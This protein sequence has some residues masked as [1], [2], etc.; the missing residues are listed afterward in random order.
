MSTNK[1]L[2]Q[3]VFRCPSCGGPVDRYDH[4]F[5]CRDC[6]A[7]GDL[8]TGIMEDLHYQPQ[9]DQKPPEETTQ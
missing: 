1:P 9:Q 4:C 8:T 5:E 7:L 2:A 3:N 6:G